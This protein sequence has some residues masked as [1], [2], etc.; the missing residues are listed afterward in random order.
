[1]NDIVRE[2]TIS[3]IRR[4]LEKQSPVFILE[5]A[6][7][8]SAHP[9]IYRLLIWSVKMIKIGSLSHLHYLI[10]SLFKTPA[11]PQK[12]QLSIDTSLECWKFF[13]QEKRF[14]LR[15]KHAYFWSSENDRFNIWETNLLSWFLLSSG[16]MDQD[17]TIGVRIKWV[18]N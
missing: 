2:L 16:T 13:I 5:L 3:Q 17:T 18:L 4:G 15:W 11:S 14:N 8:M 1:M 10:I 9:C 6:M 12:C 7:K